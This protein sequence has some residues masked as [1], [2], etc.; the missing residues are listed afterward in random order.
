MGT[1]TAIFWLAALTIGLILHILRDFRKH[2]E[3]KGMIEGKK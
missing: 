3:L 2:S 1:G